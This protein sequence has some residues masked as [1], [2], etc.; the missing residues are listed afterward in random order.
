ML[1]DVKHKITDFGIGAST[2]KGEGV[3]IK[4]GVSSVASDIPLTI[5]NGMEPEEVREKLGYTPL[6]DS[7]IESLQA[8]CHMLYAMPIKAGEEGVVK[9]VKG[10]LTGTGALTV[11]GTPANTFKII[12]KITA[13][14]TRNIGAFKVVVDE[15]GELEEETIPNEGSYVIPNTGLTL[16]FSEGEYKQSEALTFETTKPKMN[17]EGVLKALGKIKNLPL[18]FEFVHITGESEKEL[19]AALAVE[20]DKFFDVY[21]KPCIFVCETRGI[22]TDETLDAYMQYLRLEKQGVVS[23]NLQVVSAQ[24]SYM[25]EGKKVD[26]NAASVIMGLHARAKVQQS[27][28]EVAVFDIK[29]TL[30]LLP[31]GIEDYLSELDDL[32]YTTLRQYAGVEGIYINNSKTFAKEGSDYIY[33]ERVRTMYKAVRETR[34]TALL[35]IHSQIDLSNMEK[36]IK[37][38]TEFINI[39]VERMV[40]EKELSMARVIIP[41]GQDILGTE[42]LNFKIRAVPIGILREI[43]I[44]MGFENPALKKE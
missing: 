8:G 34:K 3:H 1:K 31:I 27:I 30:E 12:V 7:V 25:R 32:G 18:H 6:S 41:E 16:K 11:E 33:T 5:T 21:Y 22:G 10:T 36:S 40:E 29:G 15:I 19:W 43:E 35:K 2:V 37:A 42:K 13:S 4:I 24:V 9:E 39:P 20:G 14:G 17:N 44:D 28:G 23:R 26:I 38:I